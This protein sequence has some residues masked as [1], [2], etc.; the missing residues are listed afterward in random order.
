MIAETDETYLDRFVDEIMSLNTKIVLLL[1]TPVHSLLTLQ[2]FVDR[3]AKRGDY[4]FIG[5]Y[6]VS[7]PSLRT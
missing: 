1:A 7:T 6:W 2:K 3:G 5:D 4:V